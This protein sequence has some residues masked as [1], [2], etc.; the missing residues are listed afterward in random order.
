VD[1]QHVDGADRRSDLLRQWRAFVRAAAFEGEAAGE[2][3]ETRL[4][5]LM[6]LVEDAFLEARQPRLDHPDGERP[7][8]R[9][10]QQFAAVAGDPGAARDHFFPH[11]ERDD[12]DRRHHL[13]WLD[14]RVGRQR[15]QGHRLVDEIELVEAIAVEDQQALCLSEE[16]G[17]AGKGGGTANAGSGDCSR[18]PR[19]RRVLADIA[20]FEP[21]DGDLVDPRGGDLREI[22]GRQDTAFLECGFAEAEAMDED[23]AFRRLDR[24]LA[25]LHS[26]P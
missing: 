26:G 2:R 15:A 9:D 1:Q 16:I 14:D 8:R 22:T 6:R 4:R 11:R 7:E 20:G 13:L 10:P 23:R 24:N 21:D 5:H 25:E 19:G 18:N 3:I 17:A 12:F